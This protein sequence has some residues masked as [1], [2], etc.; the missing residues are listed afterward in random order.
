[1]QQSFREG[2]FVIIF[3]VKLCVTC[4][5]ILFITFVLL[6]ANDG[7]CFPASDAQLMKLVAAAT[8]PALVGSAGATPIYWRWHPQESPR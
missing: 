4:A 8:A 1:M 3:F 6:M 7:F 2:I 5:R